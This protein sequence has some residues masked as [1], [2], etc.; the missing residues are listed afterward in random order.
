MVSLLPVSRDCLLGLDMSSIASS[1]LSF[2]TGYDRSC[3]SL[4]RKVKDVATYNHWITLHGLVI[5]EC[6]YL[7][8]SSW[9]SFLSTK[10]NMGSYLLVSMEP[11]LR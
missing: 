6:S 4:L 3:P 11:C 7:P 5:V 10:H 8:L 2:L 1:F 9:D